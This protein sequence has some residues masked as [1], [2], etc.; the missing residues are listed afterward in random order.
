[1]IEQY[2][3]MDNFYHAMLGHHVDTMGAMI[4]PVARLFLEL[5]KTLSD[6][7]PLGTLIHYAEYKPFE[8]LPSHIKR[9]VFGLLRVFDGTRL[10][11]ET[12]S[13]Q[14]TF[15]AFLL[16][17]FPADPTEA[18]RLHITGCLKIMA[19][20]L[21]FNICGSPS[22]FLRNKDV[23]N[24]EALKREHISSHLGYACRHWANQV[25]KLDSLDPDLLNMLSQLFQT[26]FLHW[27]EVMSILDFSPVEALKNLDA[28]RVSE[29]MIFGTGIYCKY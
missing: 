20:E 10:I 3:G 21:R 28:V 23:P 18:D 5:Q 6:R 16:D 14:H 13:W 8:A 27:L 24:V 26:H 17:S 12:P 25:S 22:S 9:S 19:K 29:P 15:E 4:I 2:G 1:M 11:G 7:L